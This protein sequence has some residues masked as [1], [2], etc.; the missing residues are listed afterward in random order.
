MSTYLPQITAVDLPSSVLPIIVSKVDSTIIQLRS[1]SYHDSVF[2]C[3]RAMYRRIISFALLQNLMLFGGERDEQNRK[4]L[5][6]TNVLHF[7][8]NVTCG[9]QHITIQWQTVEA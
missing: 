6:N 2:C 9:L 4:P 7:E 8:V 3:R 1:Y 5:R